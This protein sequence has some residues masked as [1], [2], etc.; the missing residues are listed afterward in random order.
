M[1]EEELQRRIAE[2]NAKAPQWA[3]DAFDDYMM[4]KRAGTIREQG[5]AP[6]DYY[7]AFAP[8]IY[9]DEP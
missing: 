8:G 7:T 2:L 6:A 5:D 4:R 3:K 9:D 1:T